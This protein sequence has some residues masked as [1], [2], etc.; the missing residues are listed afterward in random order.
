MNISVL[1]TPHFTF[2]VVRFKC[3]IHTFDKVTLLKQFW[4]FLDPAAPWRQADPAGVQ[5]VCRPVSH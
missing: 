2:P 1:F 5:L 4:W 3:H